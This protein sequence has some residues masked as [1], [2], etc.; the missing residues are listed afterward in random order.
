[1]VPVTSYS[2]PVNRVA[3]CL[4]QTLLTIKCTVSLREEILCSQLNCVCLSLRFDCYMVV[5]LL[6]G[7]FPVSLFCVS[8]CVAVL[9]T[10]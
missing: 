7:S 10:E 6:F 4:W 9:M 1:M 3:L 2:V 5:E 8:M